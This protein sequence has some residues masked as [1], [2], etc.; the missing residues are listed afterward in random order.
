MSLKDVMYGLLLPSGNDCAM[1]LA[2][3]VA[4]SID[5]FAEMMNAK[6]QEIG[7]TSSHFVNPSGLFDAEHYTTASDLALIAEYAFRNSTFV[8]IISHP[9][10]V[11]EPTNM[12][13]D[14]RVLTNTHEMITPGN[15]DYSSD[16]IGGKT[17][18][19]YESGRCLVTYAKRNDITLISVILDGSY[20]GIFT[21]TQE[22]L[23]YGWNNFN[24]VNIS[25]SERRFSFA[26][27]NARVRMDTSRLLLSL[28]NV[29][30]SELTSQVHYAYYLDG[31]GYAAV[32][33]DAGL[34]MD[35]PRQLYAYI[36]YFYAG[37]FLGRGIIYIDPDIQVTKAT[38]INVYY[39]NVF[40]V[41]LIVLL[42]I[43]AMIFIIRMARKNSGPDSFRSRLRRRGKRG[44]VRYYNKSD[45]VDLRN[46][47]IRRGSRDRDSIS[48]LN[49][50][51][52][53]HRVRSN[54]GYMADMRQAERENTRY[55]RSYDFSRKNKERER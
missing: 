30:F 8:D 47:Y 10:Y 52:I 41:I 25:E 26:E 45:S 37:H 2:L 34:E 16:V 21:E 17:G 54:T 9:T 15:A 32:K 24:I 51:G 6:A 33:E 14:S 46:Q 49:E 42:V 7:A 29:P 39:I 48:D 40:L 36:D 12:H 44:R 23:D 22:L 31:A 1:A 55:S 27:D 3:H 28:N 35:D 5:A 19:L 18:Y 4:G 38:F 20:Y 43:L 11:I 50:I 53:P 13:T